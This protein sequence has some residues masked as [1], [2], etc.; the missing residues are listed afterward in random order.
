MTQST[1]KLIG[2]IYIIG[3]IFLYAGIVMW[4]YMSFLGDAPWYVLI[5]FFGIT[6]ACWFFPATWIIRWMARPD[7]TPGN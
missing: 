2:T 6:G 5:V 3:S 1:R 4:I 7:P